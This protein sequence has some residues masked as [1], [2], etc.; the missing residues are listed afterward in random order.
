MQ[1]QVSGWI[2]GPCSL[3]ELCWPVSHPFGTEIN[4]NSVGHDLVPKQVICPRTRLAKR[5]FIW[6]TEKSTFHV[7]LLNGLIHP[8]SNFIVNPRWEGL[9]R[10]VCLPWQLEFVFLWS[11][12][13]PCERLQLVSAIGISDI[14][15]CPLQGH[16]FSLCRV[17]LSR[18]G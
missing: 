17:Q 11:F 15:C 5:V 18:S 4:S 10:R 14:Q 7:H 8:L 9:K 13:R 3:L 16:G 1:Y 6:A 12:Q 2:L